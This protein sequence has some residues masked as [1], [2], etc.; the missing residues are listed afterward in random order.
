[1]S[2]ADLPPSAVSIWPVQDPCISGL[3][4]PAQDLDRQDSEVHAAPGQGHL[5]PLAPGAVSPRRAI[6]ETEIAAERARISSRVDGRSGAGPEAGA[7][8]L[9]RSELTITRRADP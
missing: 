2:E 1:M 4:G 5:G 7:F 3:R 6:V 8:S 9:N